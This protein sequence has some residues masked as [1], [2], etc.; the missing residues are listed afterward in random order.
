[1]VTIFAVQWPL[2]PYPESLSFLT[3]METKC[4]QETVQGR[5]GQASLQKED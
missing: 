5:A 3:T 2:S 4:F 1:M